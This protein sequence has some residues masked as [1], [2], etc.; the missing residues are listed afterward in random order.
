MYTRNNPDGMANLRHL[1][2]QSQLI[3]QMARMDRRLLAKKLLIG[4]AVWLTGTALVA[5][6]MKFQQAIDAQNQPK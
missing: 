1:H 3:Q 4:S 6:G 5:A 2:A